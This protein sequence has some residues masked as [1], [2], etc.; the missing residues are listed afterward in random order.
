MNGVTSFFIDPDTGETVKALDIINGLVTVIGSGID[1][2]ITGHTMTLTVNGGGGGSGSNGEDGDSAYE[3]AVANGFVGDESAWLDSLVGETGDA[4]Q[5][6][7]D[8]S[9]GDTGPIGPTGATGPNAVTTTTSTDLTGLLKGDGNNVQLATPGTDYLVPADITAADTK[10]T[11]AEADS[12]TLVD[13][14][15]NN[16]IKRLSWANLRAAVR[17]W[18]PSISSVWSVSQIPGVY[19]V[20]F[21]STI[22]DDWQANKQPVRALTLAGDDTEYTVS[23]S[24]NVTTPSDASEYIYSRKLYSVLQDGT[25]GHTVTFSGIGGTEPTIDTAADAETTFEVEIVRGNARFV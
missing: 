12:V 23:D 7:M 21:A 11:P 16:A 3:I 2:D 20:T 15:D 1:V 5:N 17:S 4:G 22:T 24:K 14:E 13:S 8:G 6:G 25:G 18:L 10:A 19:E 9:V